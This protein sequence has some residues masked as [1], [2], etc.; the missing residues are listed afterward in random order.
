MRWL[1]APDAGRRM[2]ERRTVAPPAAWDQSSGTAS[3]VHWNAPGEQECQDSEGGAGVAADDPGDDGAVLGVT[4]G[5]ALEVVAEGDAVSL[6][7]AVGPDWPDVPGEGA[8]TCL[9]VVQAVASRA[10]P[11]SREAR[12]PR[13]VVRMCLQDSAHRL[14]T[15]A[16]DLCPGP[17]GGALWR[18]W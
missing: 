4:L 16:V 6:A 2:S 18:S 7:V 13:G 1:F 3:V 14:E 5:D 9:W 11:S 17:K 15:A 8:A 10:A 12:G